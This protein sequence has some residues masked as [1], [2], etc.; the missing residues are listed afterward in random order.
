MKDVW[1]PYFPGSLAEL[2]AFLGR[3]EGQKPGD[4]ERIIRAGNH[5]IAAIEAIVSRRLVVRNYRDAV[6]VSSCTVT[7]GD[8]TV[9]GSGFSTYAKASD[10]AIGTGLQPGSRVASITSDSSLELDREA[11]TTGTVTVSFGSE[12]IRMDGDGTTAL[13]FQEYPV[14]EVYSIASVDAAG[15]ET[16]IDLSGARLSKEVGR[17]VLTNDV[18]PEGTLNLLVAFRAGYIEPTATDR[19][20]FSKWTALQRVAFRAAACYFADE[21]SQAGRVV[22]RS[23]GSVTTQLPSFKLPDDIVQDVL[24]HFRRLW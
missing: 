17:Y 5:A 13:Q 22:D 21:A 20:D 3:E 2:T 10:E 15:T 18:F 16:A 23:L 19:G 14:Q 11:E 4:L 8:A 1:T 6:A 24:Q 9:T 7:A 12:R